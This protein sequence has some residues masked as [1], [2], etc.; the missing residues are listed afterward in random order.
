MVHGISE[1]A[2]AIQIATWESA[3]P[4]Y[5][6]LAYLPS[7]GIIRLRISASGGNYYLLEREMT[8]QVEMLK[9]LLGEKL[10]YDDDVKVESVIGNLFLDNGKTLA[11]AESCTGGNIAHLLTLM[12]GS[13]G[14][15]QGGIVA[16]SNE[17]KESV[18]GVSRQTLLEN[19]AVSEAVVMEMA[20]N[21][22]RRF[23]THYG[24]G[25]SGIA[26]PGGGTAEKPVGT[27]WIA[28]FNG[29]ETVASGFF[30]GDNRERNIT[31]ASISALN[32][33]RLQ[34]LKDI[35]VVEKKFKKNL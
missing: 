15:F 10:F 19:G 22:A 29:T 3:L 32:M 13:S 11:V 26:G 14:Y 24:L 4:D 16:Y 33:L 35:G 30:F 18:L 34:V 7:P 31:R 21:V 12:P 25:I 9:P 20:G 1:S 27:V 6:K 23:G 2:L 28:V 17:I 5:M 8:K